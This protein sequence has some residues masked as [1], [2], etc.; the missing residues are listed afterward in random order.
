MTV[1]S[2]PEAWGAHKLG[3]KFMVN[4]RDTY[5]NYRHAPAA[6]FSW[7]HAQWGGISDGA[8]IDAGS[9]VCF[10][11]YSHAQWFDITWHSES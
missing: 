10:R 7:L 3:Y 8:W 11:E 4:T 6:Y 2:V 1:E 5:Q 9:Y